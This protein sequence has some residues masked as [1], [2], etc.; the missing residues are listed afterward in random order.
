M[1]QRMTGY[2]KEAPVSIT[3]ATEDLKGDIERIMEALGGPEAFFSPEDRILLK[4]NINSHLDSPAAVDPHFLG[5]FID[6][7]QESGYNNLAVAEAS[8]RTW[9]PTERV[10][11]DKGLL[12]F[13]EER[14]V[15]FFALDD[16]EWKAVETG[17]TALPRVHIPAIL[18]DFDR[19]VFLPSLKTH[20]NT[21]YTLTIKVAMGLTPLADRQ[22]FH[23]GSVAAAIADLAR[24]VSP[25]L[26]VIDG[27]RAFVAGGPD[28][29]TLVEPGLLMASPSSVALDIEAVRI[30]LQYGAG[31]H[32]GETDPLETETIRRMGDRVPERITVRWV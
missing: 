6:Y 8:G 11:D 30:L 3:R 32:I 16:L 28:T 4:P 25:D 26:A 5:T 27:R 22:L 7:L 18:E 12:P 19:L 24:V 23:D 31:P 14:G 15:P 29:G 10:V 2:T 20:G 13:L 9:A 21:G 1:P 17:G